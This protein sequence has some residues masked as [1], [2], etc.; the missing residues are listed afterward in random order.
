MRYDAHNGY[1]LKDRA[2][3]S[4]GVES[5]IGFVSQRKTHCKP[6]PLDMIRQPSSLNLES[7]CDGDV[8]TAVKDLLKLKKKHGELPKSKFWKVQRVKEACFKLETA[9]QERG[10]ESG[11][12]T[13][14][15]RNDVLDPIM[16]VLNTTRQTFNKKLDAAFLEL[17]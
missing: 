3:I 15:P 14:R 6:V 5:T 9:F 10:W 16:N 17:A 1:D 11:V 13:S 4:E 7:V 8:L 2:F 12:A